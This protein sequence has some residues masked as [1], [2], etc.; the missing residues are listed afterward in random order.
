MVARGA[1]SRLFHEVKKCEGPF[2][3]VTYSHVPETNPYIVQAHRLLH[4]AL[5]VARPVPPP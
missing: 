2:E 5:E 3:V 4:K 1:C